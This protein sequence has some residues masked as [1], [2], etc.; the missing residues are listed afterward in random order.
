MDDSPQAVS[1]SRK[2]C[3]RSRRLTLGL[4]TLGLLTHGAG[5]PNSHMVWAGVASVAQ[6]RD[7]NL[8]CFPG[9]LLRSPLEFE[10]QSNVLYELVS[11]QSIDGLVI[12]SAGLP[13]FVERQE[14]NA[15]CQRF[16]PL[17][18]VTA[19]V[20]I[21]GI[22]GVSVDNYRGMRAVVSHLIEV[23]RRTVIAFIRGP[24]YHQE[25]EE[26]Y[27]AYLDV[28]ADHDI[29]FDPGLVVQ[30]NFKESGGAAAA[31]QLMLSR[32]DGF[33]ALVAASDNMAIGALRV[34]QAHGLRVPGD[35]AL[36]GL[37]DESQSPFVTPPLTT[38]P[39]HFYEQ[40]RRATE[41]L[42][43]L[44]AGAPVTGQV[45]LPTQLLIR[46]SCGCPDPLVTQAAADVEVG[47]T[48]GA[49]FGDIALVPGPW[50]K[51]PKG[52][53]DVAEWYMST[54]TRKDYVLQVFERQC[55]IAMENLPRVYDAVGDRV[56]VAWISGTDFGSQNSC[57][58]SP[59]A[60]RT[61]YKPFYTRVNAWIHAHT[62]W[63]TFIHSCGSIQPLI[64]DII[65]AGFDIL[66]PVQ[67]SAANMDPAEL[68]ARFGSQV[69][70]WG[71]GVDTQHALPFGTPD[72]VRA[73]VRERLRIFGK[74]GGFVFNPIHNVQAKVPV[75]N[76]LA[77][78]ETVR[79]YGRY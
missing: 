34:L 31:E 12:W 61:L 50:V 22:P 16:S 73:Q 49:R 79:E 29:P 46:Q 10:A 14:M 38:G 64:P 20:P 17:P 30:S 2:I 19:G 21:E 78:Y 39:L 3:P 7:V 66:N 47:M 48:S 8:I 33:D 45:V 23:H 76:L 51:H 60:F 57:F 36:A 70:F 4:L 67:T 62:P 1:S 42:L 69:T 24:E 26:R 5:D 32:R 11:Q 37:N 71:G 41:M 53:R 27:R 15:F 63:K 43:A 25:A 59:R 72:E 68:K 18:M 6:E 13:L 28:L 44:L 54:V 65:E 75:G 9:K 58:I 77:M 52:I 56:T 35:V 40:A 74:G 55:E